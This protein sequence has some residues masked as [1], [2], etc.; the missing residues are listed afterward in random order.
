MNKLWAFGD[1]MTAGHELGTGYTQEYIEAWLEATAGTPHIDIARQTLGGEQY[2]LR[3]SR[4]WYKH[5]KESCAPDL[6]WAGIIARR[7]GYQL[8]PHAV[9]GAGLDWCLD[10]LERHYKDIDWDNDLVVIGVPPLKRW[11]MINNGNAS[12]NRV[13]VRDPKLLIRHKSLI[14][15]NISL[16]YTIKS[17]FPKTVIVD[18]GLNNSLKDFHETSPLINLDIIPIINDIALDV[19]ADNEINSR[20]PGH[21]P[22]EFVHEQFVDYLLENYN[23]TFRNNNNG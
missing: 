23:E 19:F 1:S 12:W 16:L 18:M 5:I 10:R 20:Y 22:K 21:H 11:K 15:F 2:H 13:R 14:N 8:E 17:L 9:P 6:A 3:V 7:L 4:P